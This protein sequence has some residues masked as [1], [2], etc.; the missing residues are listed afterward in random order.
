[1]SSDVCVRH[2]ERIVNHERRIELCE[3][4][5]RSNGESINSIHDKLDLL[6]K[7]TSTQ[8]ALIPALSSIAYVL[9]EIVKHFIH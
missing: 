3:Q 6:H 1:M 5:A 2:E 9:Y 7:R 8:N 4:T